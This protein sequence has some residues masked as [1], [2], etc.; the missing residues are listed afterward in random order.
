MC[1]TAIERVIRQHHMENNGHGRSEN[2]TSFDVLVWAKYIV[3]CY[4]LLYTP[5]YDNNLAWE[6]VRFVRIIFLGMYFSF[7]VVASERH[8]TENNV[9]SRF[10]GRERCQHGEYSNDF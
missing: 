7:L 5:S 2:L 4:N 8:L 9:G 6:M 1:D 10:F 3:T